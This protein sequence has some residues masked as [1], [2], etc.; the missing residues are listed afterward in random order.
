MSNAD[1]SPSFSN[2]EIMG[3]RKFYVFGP[4]VTG[5]GRGHGLVF[6]N[7]DKLL[8]PP[9][10]I[11]RPEEGGFPPLPEKPHIG[12]DPKIGDAPRD[13]EG[14][15]SGYWFVSERLKQVFETIDPEGFAFA[16]C[17]YTLPDGSRGPTHYLCDVLRVLDV[18]DEDRSRMKPP[19]IYPGGE[20][21]YDFAGQPSLS[22]KE[23][24]IGQGDTFRLLF[25]KSVDC[26]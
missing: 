8:S 18:L 10:I 4:D 23:K 14:G 1:Q 9:R 15:M 24:A 11:V 22:F 25:R 2:H 16:E 26:R 6:V 13:L 21:V 5:G 17:D 20:K 7:E 3:A 19:T 12:Y